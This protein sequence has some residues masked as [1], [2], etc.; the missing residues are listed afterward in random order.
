MSITKMLE[1]EIIQVK[2]NREYRKNV[3]SQLRELIEEG[4]EDARVQYEILFPKWET[5]EKQEPKQYNSKLSNRKRER[6]PYMIC[7]TCGKMS[8][9]VIEMED[10]QLK[11]EKRKTWKR[12][13]RPN[14]N[15]KLKIGVRSNLRNRRLFF[16]YNMIKCIEKRHKLTI[17][18][19]RPKT[20]KQMGFSYK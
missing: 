2:T 16:A 3:R 17:K 11:E 15:Y 20:I 5:K 8:D 10:P 4:N 7:K 9:R 13:I 14:L 18:F 1:S 19:M 12:L 6:I